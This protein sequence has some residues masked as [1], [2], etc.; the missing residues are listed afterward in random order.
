MDTLHKILQ[1]MWDKGISDMELCR[2]AGINKSAVTDWKK[3]KTQSYMKHLPEIAKVLDVTVD[4]LTTE[5][6]KP[7]DEDGG[8]N[9]DIAEIAR[10]TEDFTDEEL[11]ALL[12]Y[13]EFLISKRKK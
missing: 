2:S 3:G 8:L 9:E 5:K 10:I 4:E 13:A 7:T 6:E 12:D 11:Q 1:L